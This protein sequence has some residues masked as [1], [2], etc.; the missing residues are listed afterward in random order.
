MNIGGDEVNQET[1]LIKIILVVLL[2]CNI[3]MSIYIW[4]FRY[5]EGYEVGY[6]EGQESGHEQGYVV[7]Q[8]EGYEEGNATG[9]SLGY[10]AGYSQG[11]FSG[12]E[13]GYIQGVNVGF[14]E[15]KEEG[16]NEGFTK[17]NTTGYSVGYDEGY[18]LGY[19]EGL[20]AVGVGYFYVRDP[21]YSEARK[22]IRHDK[23]DRQRYIPEK[24]ECVDFVAMIKKN[25]FEAGYKC[26]Y[27]AIN[28][29]EA[30]HAIVAFN[31]TDKGLIFIE[32][33]GDRIVSLEIEKPYWDRSIYEAPDYDDTVIRFI[34]V[35]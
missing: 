19:N 7:G 26:F 10:N 1:S 15:G 34:L 20:E 9:Y 13:S 29:P 35:P 22:F 27:V 5:S 3:G 28:F 6:L 8:E 14:D 2:A 16:Y 11:Y 23:T 24:F 21:T 4:G 17:G 30:G 25:A 18:E 33:Q 12:N 32:P 31:T